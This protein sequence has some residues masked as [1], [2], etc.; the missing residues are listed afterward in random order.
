VPDPIDLSAF[1]DRER[2]IGGLAP[3]PGGPHDPLMEAR[4]ARIEDDVKELKAD[5]KALR[6]D[7]A[8]L[9]GRLEQLPTT[10]VMLTA[11]VGSMVALLGF[12]FVL[13]RFALPSAG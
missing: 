1:R 13:L 6:A 7:G 12:T 10:W 8:W 4:I 5:V 2:R 3:P 11:I 9:K